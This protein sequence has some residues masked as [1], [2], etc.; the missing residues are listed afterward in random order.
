MTTTSKV[1]SA[2]PKCRHLGLASDPFQH[3]ETATA[4]HRCYL[5][6]QR[7]LIDQD[8]QKNYC[9]SSHQTECP[10]LQISMPCKGSHMARGPSRGP[11]SALKGGGR[12]AGL[13]IVSFSRLVADR[14]WVLLRT[15]AAW[16]SENVPII[17][18]RVWRA[19]APGALAAL[20]GIGSGVRRS[21]S[22]VARS[23]GKRETVKEVTLD[24]DG[25]F[26]MLMSLGREANKAG[27][28]K[29]AHLCFSKAAALDATSEEAWLWMAATAGDP[30]EA[31]GY[32]EKALTINPASGKGRA[33][34][35]DFRK[36]AAPAVHSETVAVEEGIS[37][38]VLIDQGVKA[39]DEGNED[40]A[41]HFFAAATESER[42]SESAWFWRAKTSTDLAEV[43]T[44]LERVLELNPDNE[45]AQASLKWATERRRAD[46]NRQ[47]MAYART[48]GPASRLYTKPEPARPP[49][50]LQLASLGYMFLG[51]LWIAPAILL[52][53]GSLATPYRKIGFLPFL[54][55]PYWSSSIP[56]LTEG[57]IPEFNLFYVVP[58]LLA[59]LSLVAMDTPSSPSRVNAVCVALV[60]GASVAAAVSFVPG[61][62]ALGTLLVLSSVT[63]MTALSGRLIHR[64]RLQRQAIQASEGV[65]KNAH[66]I[67]SSQ[68]GPGI[69]RIA[70]S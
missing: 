55:A 24:P 37:A 11:G 51:L 19:L 33:Q 8:H 68:S 70:I 38:Y 14:A 57:L 52:V 36:P 3:A 49:A 32:L 67:G 26:P 58:V 62:P 10:W 1:P 46:S 64:R 12:R 16:L 27:R 59:L 41:H 35:G 13:A 23:R 2:S 15:V 69:E 9:L 7:D 53:D 5:W 56:D 29:E 42:S 60:A 61:Q 54:N 65:S 18:A 63:G 4:E 31:Q 44:C 45:K 66:L 20:R 17:M 22:A 40:Q 50:I 30:G 21:G 6:M 34:L 47:R 28:R 25:D 43:I 39:M 48:Q